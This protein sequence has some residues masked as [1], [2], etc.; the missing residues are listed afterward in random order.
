MTEDVMK[1]WTRRLALLAAT[2][3]FAACAA[4]SDPQRVDVHVGQSAEAFGVTIA[5]V[6]V[7]SDDRCPVDVQCVRAGEAVVR[8]ELRTTTETKTVDLESNEGRN[9]A[10]IAGREV[11]FVDLQPQPRSTTPTD[12][13]SYVAVFTV[14]D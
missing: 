12:P 9:E 14:E 8:V 6:G 10:E 1:S 7:L 4:G 11:T 2:A 3:A 13:S 5:L